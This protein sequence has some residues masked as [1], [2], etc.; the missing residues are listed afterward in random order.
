M[1][2]KKVAVIGSGIIG[3]CSA[4]ELLKAGH[5]VTILDP[6]S[7]GGK[8]GASYGH[9]CWISPASIVP[10]SMPGLWKKVPS[11][12]LD[13]TGPLVIRWKSLPR[14]LPWL[15]RFI[16]AGATK[17][18]VE[19]TA[20]A[21]SYLLRDGPER[22]RQLAQDVGEEALIHQDGLL[23]VFPDR[24]AFEAEELS[25]NLRKANGVTWRELEH[26]VL[27]EYEPTLANRYKF[28]I[29]I[30][31]GSHCLDP[32][33]Y[34]SA[35]ADSCAQL[36]AKFVRDSARDFQ[37][38][39][40]KLVGIITGENE[41]IDCDQAVVAA[42]I[43]S[44]SLAAQAGDRIPL[45]A[46]RGYHCVITCP[47]INLKCPI[48]P[49]D[50]KMANTPTNNGL[51]L[52]GQVELADVDALADWRRV[53]ILLNHARKAYP[54]L[55]TDERKIERWMGHRPST[56]DGLPVIGY[57]NRSQ[58]IIFAFGHGHIG[59]ASGPATGRIVA[60]LI[61]GRGHDAINVAF[62]PGRFR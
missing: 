19:R 49:S 27:H 33:R 60:D 18:K 61:S 45:E 42:G 34:L 13:S 16:L 40:E 51:R 39:N 1:G 58:D 41:R 57:S 62:S 20:H 14:L 47:S 31:N 4:Y 38:E 24:Q 23:Y 32:A 26:E 50:G 2:S 43:R 8:H 25:W 56:P 15:V 48:M 21:L 53:D 29:L 22:H 44:K 5:T 28:G 55:E 52:S 37:F 6:K 7:P 36:G 3:L 11:Y 30:Q 9:G 35:I 10:M 46:E 12:L 54:A 59:F 17:A